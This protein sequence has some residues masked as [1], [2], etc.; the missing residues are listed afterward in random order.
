MADAFSSILEY[1]G[2]GSLKNWVDD[3]VFFRYPISSISSLSSFSYSL[4]NIYALASQLGW[5]WKDSKAKPFS[6]HFKYLGFSWSL[7]AKTIKILPE[8]KACYVTKLLPWNPDPRF[9]RKD[10][11]SLLGTLVHCSLALP[12]RFS[13]LSALSHFAASFH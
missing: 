11:E 8:K 4:A 2:F 10:T 6:L 5:P 3:F 1:K 7:S 12:N 13:C 9:S